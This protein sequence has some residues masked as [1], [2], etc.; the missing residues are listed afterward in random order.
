[1]VWQ[2]AQTQEALNEALEALSDN[3]RQIVMQHTGWEWEE[4]QTFAQLGHV[5]G[6]SRQRVHQL[7]QKALAILRVPALSLRLRSLYSLD[8]RDDYR[9]ALR[10]NRGYQRKYRGRR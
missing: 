8:S 1:V 10:Q 4:P 2:S 5:R 9:E 7:Y 6:V 3:L